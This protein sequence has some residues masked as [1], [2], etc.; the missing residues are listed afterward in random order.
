MI[1]M[2]DYSGVVHKSGNLPQNRFYVL[3]GNQSCAF[4]LPRRSLLPRTPQEILVV[5]LNRH[6]VPTRIADIVV[7]NAIGREKSIER[8]RKA[9]DQKHRDSHRPNQPGQTTG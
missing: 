2:G 4:K 9:T 1:F 3:G 5:E 7:Y 6:V 8:M